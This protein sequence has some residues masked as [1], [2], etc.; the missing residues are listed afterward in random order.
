MR[1]LLSVRCFVCGVLSGNV[2]VVFCDRRAPFSSPCLV[3]PGE[4]VS[5][6]LQW[7]CWRCALRV[8]GLSLTGVSFS[9][10]PGSVQRTPNPILVSRF[11]HFGFLFFFF[12]CVYIIR[13]GGA[14]VC[15]CVLRSHHKRD[16]PETREGAQLAGICVGLSPL[17]R[18]VVDGL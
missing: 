8:E 3:G 14:C 1:H 7:G 18:G 16:G 15:G 10:F 12:V 17:R 2:G 13:C 5:S 11:F 4:K 6:L 9:L